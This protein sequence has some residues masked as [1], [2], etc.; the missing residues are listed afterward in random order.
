MNYFRN[1]KGSSAAI[2]TIDTSIPQ[3]WIYSMY[4]LIT[5]TIN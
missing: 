1:L 2:F 5:S 4:V 3:P